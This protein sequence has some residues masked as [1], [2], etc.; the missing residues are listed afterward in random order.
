MNGDHGD[1]TGALP[2]S[3]AGL[4]A[5]TYANAFVRGP[6]REGMQRIQNRLHK[7][8]V[9][10]DELADYFAAR[11]EL[12]NN[13]LKSLQKLAKRSFLSDP[14]ALGPNF[15]P[16][17]ER[18]VGEIG[19]LAGVHGELERKL[20]VECE[21]PMRSA[22]S[23]GEWGRV[24][25]HDDSL[26]S[27]LKEIAALE[28]QLS[29]DQ[30]KAEGASSKKAGQAAQKVAETER[31]LQQ[32]LE[33]WETEAPFA[34]E[35]YQRIDSQRLDLMKEVVTKFE[36]ARSDA[37][38][39][40]MSSTEQSMQVVL[41]FDPQ[42]DM[43]EFALRS[44]TAKAAPGR[45]TTARSNATP[46]HS[47]QPPQIPPPSGLSRKGS[48]GASNFLG[49][50]T[51]NNA[52][53]STPTTGNVIN[54][55]GGVGQ[56][57]SASIHS[58]DRYT[59]QGT[60]SRSTGGGSTLKSALTRFGRGRS[61]RNAND[62]QTV[63]GSLP[64]GPDSSSM[65]PPSSSNKGRQGSGGGFDETR[66]IDSRS[67]SGPY[68][69]GGASA[70]GGPFGSSLMT[71]LAP[72][73]FVDTNSKSGN[74]NFL[75]QPASSV[76]APQVDAEGFSIPPP[77]RKPW[78]SNTQPLS[79]PSLMDEEE[80]E[81][82]T[83][84]SSA[85]MTGMSIAQ[86]PIAEDSDQEQ[87]A[88]ERMRST[89]LTARSP[90]LTP[91]RRNTA[92]RRDR[93]DV[94][95]TTYNPSMALD[96]GAGTNSRI[97]SYGLP[98]ASSPIGQS[99]FTGVPGTGAERSQSMISNGSTSQMGNI[100]IDPV[101]TSPGLNASITERVN[102]V[103]SGRDIT[104]IMI[105]GE[106][107]ISA[108]D[109]ISRNALHLRIESFEQLE[110]AAPNPLYLKPLEGTGARAGEYELDVGA[111]IASGGGKATLLKYQLFVSPN[112]WKEY[113][114]L[115]LTTQ[116]R[117]EDHQT[118]ILVNYSANPDLLSSVK[119]TSSSSGAFLRDLSINVEVTSPAIS[120]MMSKPT[121]NYMAEQKKLFWNLPESIALGSSGDQ[122][123][124]IN[125]VLARFQ[126]DQKSQ[127]RP[128]EVRWKLVGT[129]LSTLDLTIV[130]TQSGINFG[131][132]T[133]QLTSGKYMASP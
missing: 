104:K 25:E 28:S 11:R 129:T 27:T 24:K 109:L 82:V 107:T 29:K 108:K 43:Q 124:T 54:E 53:P 3:S 56:S 80:R 117:C 88:L 44:G 95:N 69:A 87:A 96:D 50:N 94:R 20:E 72:T 2:P 125:K 91:Q 58:T 106:V 128:I 101:S 113:V 42:T 99:I 22:S 98:Q 57:S 13:Y 79:S 40:M 119:T 111:I 81:T 4:A 86:T 49:R 132:I 85:K 1:S 78:E 74:N 71:P 36:T 73:P 39:R 60:P 59:E 61:N 89:L 41:S 5:G 15:L 30:K 77:D 116:W 12:E 34:F 130:D 97:S 51:S 133:R 115:N 103:F 70:A 75:S 84:L 18:L 33:L 123:P 112:R 52:A 46:T 126:V 26:S 7:A 76:A 114:P 100:S 83:D 105:V 65:Q 16:V 62:T 8:R 48:L 14:S 64:E 21:I 45:S 90:V 55:F 93:R 131:E 9:L 32:T 17:Y 37:A 6:P 19:E 118:S 31:S 127:I 67:E 122:V 68:A 35:A 38:Q 66:S 10:T 92:S 120:N 23:K 110:K 121:A 47:S 63:Y 102:V